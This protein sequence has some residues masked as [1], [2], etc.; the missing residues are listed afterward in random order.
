MKLDEKVFQ[1]EV[2][3][4][5]GTYLLFEQTNNEPQLQYSCMANKKIKFNRVLLEPKKSKLK[6]RK[7]KTDKE[8]QSD[9]VSTEEDPNVLNKEFIQYIVCEQLFL[10][11]WV[12]SFHA[13]DND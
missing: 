9:T 11:V 4:C 3:E 5:A 2:D 7:K 10:C 1:G 12:S 8:S 6:K 13:H